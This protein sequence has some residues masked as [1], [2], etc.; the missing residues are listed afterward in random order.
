MDA[1]RGE[2]CS[3]MTKLFFTPRPTLLSLFK[4]VVA[5]I[6]LYVKSFFPLRKIVKIAF[7]YE[8]RTRITSRARIS[9]AYT[10]K[11]NNTI[12]FHPLSPLRFD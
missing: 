5:H 3:K 11:K 4:H 7:I 9:N 1:H 8:Y 10:E 6:H 2:H 12:Y